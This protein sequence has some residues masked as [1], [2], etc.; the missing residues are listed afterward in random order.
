M[1]TGSHVRLAS[2]DLARDS[3]AQAACRSKRDECCLRSFP[4]A[5]LQR[6]LRGSQL[7][8]VHAH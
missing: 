3:L 4:I 5:I 1:E 2:F 6:S 8:S 7:V